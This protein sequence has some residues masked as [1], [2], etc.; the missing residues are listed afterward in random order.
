MSDMYGKTRFFEDGDWGMA[1]MANIPKLGSSKRFKDESLY[2]D[3]GAEIVY[4]S[5]YRADSSNLIMRQRF[6]K[7]IDRCLKSLNH[8]SLLHYIASNEGYSFP[9]ELDDNRYDP[10]EF[11]L[12]ELHN[13]FAY[14]DNS[15]ESW[16]AD[17]AALIG[18]E[19]YN[20][21]YGCRNQNITLAQ[22][23]DELILMRKLGPEGYLNRVRYAMLKT[24]KRM[25]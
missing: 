9:E 13:T 25:G 23:K 22:F 6:Y 21:I 5:N 7:S 24:P 14:F 12:S 3:R 17:V 8:A 19:D 20:P 11:A 16:L 10:A 4:Q 18:G 2:R 15:E 1:S